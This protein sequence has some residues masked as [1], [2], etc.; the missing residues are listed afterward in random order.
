MP[1]LIMSSLNQSPIDDTHTGPS[2]FLPHTDKS[3]CYLMRAT[4]Q[5]F[6]PMSLIVQVDSGH[7]P[8]AKPPCLSPTSISINPPLARKSNVVQRGRNCGYSVAQD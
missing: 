3:R 5:T 8:S 1:P 7:L 6:C 4:D 2:R